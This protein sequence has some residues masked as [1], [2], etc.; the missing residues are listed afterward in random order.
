MI[1]SFQNG[2]AL[3]AIIHRYRPD[4]IDFSSLDPQDIHLNN[5]LAFDILECELGLPPLT[6]GQEVAG[7]AEAGRPPDKLAMIS[8]L[9]QIYELFR[10]EIPSTLQQDLQGEVDDLD[11]SLYCHN[12]KDGRAKKNKRRD[13]KE[14]T[15]TIG[16]LVAND[17][18]QRK[19]KKSSIL[20]D[21]LGDVPEEDKA[22]RV[23]NKKRLC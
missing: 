2:L 9:T 23:S 11:D 17:A 14:N 19:Q 3:C 13:M 1:T 16:Q 12:H 18:V 21:E 10:K 5:Q 8:Y 4:L 6:T 7:N 20:K 15:K 22:A